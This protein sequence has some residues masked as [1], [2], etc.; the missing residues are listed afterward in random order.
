MLVNDVKIMFTLMHFHIHT[1][2]CGKIFIRTRDSDSDVN[3][4]DSDL[5]S[6]GRGLGFGLGLGWP[7]TRTWTRTGGLDYN[8]G[9]FRLFL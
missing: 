9:H 1:L 7:G 3:D 5:D 2:L 8:T 6:T 4:S